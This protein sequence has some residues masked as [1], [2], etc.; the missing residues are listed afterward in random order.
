MRNEEENIECNDLTKFKNV[1]YNNF[2]NKLHY[3]NIFSKYLKTYIPSSVTKISLIINKDIKINNLQ[4]KT[5]HLCFVKTV[6]YNDNI[7]LREIS[8]NKLKY[9]FDCYSNS[10]SYNKA[11]ITVLI[12]KSHLLKVCINSKH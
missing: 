4:N 10:V 5:K 8:N 9:C 7:I 3:L 12:N 6:C 2:S 1:K 11:I